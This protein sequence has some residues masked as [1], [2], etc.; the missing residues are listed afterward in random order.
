MPISVL[1][2]HSSILRDYKEAWDES[3]TA[4]S[5][6]TLFRSLSDHPW[7]SFRDLWFDVRFDL[8]LLRAF[9]DL[10]GDPSQKEELTRFTR[11]LG[12]DLGQARK[13]WAM[14]EAQEE[15]I[16][17]VA[18]ERPWQ[19]VWDVPNVESEVQRKEQE[20]LREWGIEP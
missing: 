9:R 6:H 8:E 2:P 14:R 16:G 20:I 12:R 11:V 1:S 18:H 10:T 4:V 17:K 13:I 3:E 15:L 5:M 7:A 19:S